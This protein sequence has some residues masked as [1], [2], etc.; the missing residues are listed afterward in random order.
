MERRLPLDAAA[1][2]GHGPALGVVR[3]SDAGRTVL[4]GPQ[5]SES[6]LSSATGSLPLRGKRS[7]SCWDVGTLRWRT[8]PTGS[9]E[10]EHFR[11]MLDELPPAAL[12]AADAGFVGYEYLRAVIDS[13]RQ[14]LVRV[15]SNVRL[16]RKLG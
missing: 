14:M 12:I 15:G 9:S 1:S 11:Q 7:S 2:G 4:R 13:G 16:L 6:S 8:G 3:R 10:R 5:I